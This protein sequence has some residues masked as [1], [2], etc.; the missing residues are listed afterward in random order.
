MSSLPYGNEADIIWR[1]CSRDNVQALTRFSKNFEPGRQCC[2]VRNS[3][4]PSRKLPPYKK[5]MTISQVNMIR[6][7]NLVNMHTPKW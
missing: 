6:R 3:P 4:T 5:S 7:Q 1:D 2:Y